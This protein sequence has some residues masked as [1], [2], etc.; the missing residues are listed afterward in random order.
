MQY[1]SNNRTNHHQITKR[2]KEGDINAAK[3]LIPSVRPPLM[4][5]CNSH[6][7]QEGMSKEKQHSTKAEGSEG[8]QAHASARAPRCSSPLELCSGSQSR[9][10]KGLGKEYRVVA[11]IK[12]VQFFL[13]FLKMKKN[14]TPDCPSS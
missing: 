5:L 3:P 1:L 9:E 4:G 8:P 10:L 12:Q 2:E 6:L 13:K 14:I 7:T 11:N